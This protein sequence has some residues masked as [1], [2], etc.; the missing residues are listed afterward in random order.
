MK[1]SSAALFA[2]LVVAGF[3][4][5]AHAGVEDGDDLDISIVLPLMA[6]VE[7]YTGVKAEMLPKVIASHKLLIKTTSHLKDQSA[8]HMAVGAYIPGVVIVDDR[9]W[10]PNDPVELS[11]LVHELVHHDQ[12]YMQ[13]TD[14][15]HEEMER[16]AYTLQNKYLTDRG[17]SPFKDIAAGSLKLHCPGSNDKIAE[18]KKP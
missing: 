12:L 16:Q 13:T 10:D 2:F 1:R 8:N 14:A 5:E 4:P 11:I 17:E 9:N 3:C 18:N 7:H 6:W 15:C